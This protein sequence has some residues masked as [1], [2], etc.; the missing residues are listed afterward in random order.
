MCMFWCFWSHA[1]FF[2]CSSRHAIITCY[3]FFVFDAMCMVFECFG[4][5]PPLFPICCFGCLWWYVHC[6]PI[7]GPTTIRGYMCFCC[8]FV[9]VH[10][11]CMAFYWFS[12]Q[13]TVTCHLSRLFLFFVYSMPYAWFSLIDCLLAGLIVWLIGWSAE[14]QAQVSTDSCNS[15]SQQIISAVDLSRSS[16]QLSRKSQQLIS[17]D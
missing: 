2:N 4:D 13:V 9:F 15:W 12:R 3:M 8:V 7:S 6:F 17:T 11:M 16:Q 10:I 1:L 14:S 5:E